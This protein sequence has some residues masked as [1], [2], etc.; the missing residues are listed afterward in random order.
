MGVGKRPHLHRSAMKHDSELPTR[1]TALRNRDLPDVPWN[2]ISGPQASTGSPG[3]GTELSEGTIHA[4][5]RR[6]KLEGIL[7]GDTFS[8]DAEQERLVPGSMIAHDPHRTIPPEAQ[9]LWRS[10]RAEGDTVGLSTWRYS[11]DS[12]LARIQHPDPS[13]GSQNHCRHRVCGRNGHAHGDLHTRPGIGYCKQAIGWTDQVHTA[14]CS[15]GHARRSS[16]ALDRHK[17]E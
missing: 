15:H 2:K 16:T 7:S 1:T 9:A 4:W 3:Q 14:V 12:G 17:G 10:S 8:R 5:E 6:R 13:L 11:V